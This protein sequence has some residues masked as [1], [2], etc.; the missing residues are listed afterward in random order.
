ML[1]AAARRAAGAWAEAVDG[2][3]DALLA[4]ASPEAATAL[5]YGGDSTRGTRLVVRGASVKRIEIAGVQ[6]DALPATMSV[7]VE[8]GGR[9]YTEDRDTAAVVSGSKDRATTFTETWTL[10]LD[11]PPEAPWRLIS[12]GA[13]GAP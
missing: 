5:L 9:R 10:A 12:L 13:A 4:V 3:D 8:L 6:V 2:A 11:G 1:E 7:L